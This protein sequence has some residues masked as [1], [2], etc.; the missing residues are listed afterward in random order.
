MYNGQIVDIIKKIVD[1]S[2]TIQKN[3]VDFTLRYSRKYD[4]GNN[5]FF[6]R[7]SYDI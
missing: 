2:W 7:F 6:I 4:Y 5:S 3:S 1:K